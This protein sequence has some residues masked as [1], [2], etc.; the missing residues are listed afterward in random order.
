LVDTHWRKVVDVLKPQR[1][2]D[3]I[4]K[5]GFVPVAIGQTTWDELSPLLAEISF[6]VSAARALPLSTKTSV[7]VIALT[8][9][10]G[11]ADEIEPVL[12]EGLQ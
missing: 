1:D 5:Q 3:K 11:C 10:N 12:P 8:A 9:E 7:R 2:W 6:F 4:R